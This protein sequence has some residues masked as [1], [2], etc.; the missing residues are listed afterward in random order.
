MMST[1]VDTADLVAESCAVLL[2]ARNS[3]AARRAVL[4]PGVASGRGPLLFTAM[5][6]S[7]GR[8]D[9]CRRRWLRGSL[10]VVT[11]VPVLYDHTAFV[12]ADPEM[13]ADGGGVTQVPGVIGQLLAWRHTDVGCDVFGVIHDA[14]TSATGDKIRERLWGYAELGV[15]PD[16][17][18][19]ATSDPDLELSEMRGRGETWLYRAHLFELSILLS[20]GAARDAEVTSWGEV[21]TWA[22]EQ[23]ADD[24][25]QED[26]CALR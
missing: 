18:V 14:Q 7:W 15:L 8:V 13:V 2:R 25:D 4:M 20:R 6:V 23:L 26:R 19:G 22:A 1:D 9:D 11:P 10:D 17:S 5:A 21:P 24:Q 12:D 3:A 16:V